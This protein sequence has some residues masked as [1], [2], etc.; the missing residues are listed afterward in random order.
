MIN[1]LK[2]NKIL[3]GVTTLLTFIAAIYGLIDNNIYSGLFP[4][5]FIAAQFSQDWLT[6]AVCIFL[7]YLILA[8]K[9]DSIKRP[10]ISSVSWVRWR[11]FT[12]FFR[13]SVFTTCYIWFT[14]QSW[15][16]LSSLLYLPFL[17]SIKMS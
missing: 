17:H 11:I 2:N 14:W 6:I 1:N 4:L 5:K 10:I 16:P 12:E 9:P 15:G 13:S 7:G 8:T 3:W